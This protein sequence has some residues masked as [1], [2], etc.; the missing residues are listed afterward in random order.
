MLQVPVTPFAL[1]N[2]SL[3]LRSKNIQVEQG[4]S[5]VGGASEQFKRPDKNRVFF[6]KRGKGA[7]HGDTIR[8]GIIDIS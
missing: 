3:E 2:I 6:I 5:A 8:K 4:F 1:V 7:G